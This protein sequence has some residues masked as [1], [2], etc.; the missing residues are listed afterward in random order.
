MIHDGKFIVAPS[1]PSW[2]LPEKKT[3]SP[4][5][6]DFSII[7]PATVGQSWVGLPALRTWKDS[8]VNSLLVSVRVTV[9]QDLPFLAVT[10]G[11]WM[12][13]NFRCDEQWSFHPGWLGYIDAIISHDMR[14]P[15]NQPV[16][17]G[18]CHDCGQVLITSPHVCDVGIQVEKTFWSLGPFFGHS[19]R[20]QPEPNYRPSPPQEIRP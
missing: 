9:L 12:E 10:L 13:W 8:A 2:G 11:T 4:K 16:F 20:F 7:F 3:P 14:I 17:H 19:W 6:R 1:V 5:E 15:I 18:S